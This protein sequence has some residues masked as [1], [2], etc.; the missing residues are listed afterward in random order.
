MNEFEGLF[1]RSVVVLIDYFEP[2]LL[3]AQSIL[4]HYF[5]ISLAIACP[6]VRCASAL[7]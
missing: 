5:D 2:V 4:S 7:K 3:E 6:K 1:E